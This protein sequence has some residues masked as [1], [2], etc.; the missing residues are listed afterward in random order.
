[1]LLGNLISYAKKVLDRLEKTGCGDESDPCIVAL[2]NL[3]TL[4]PKFESDLSKIKGNTIKGNQQ[5]GTIFKN[6]IEHA[7]R[8][9]I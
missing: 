9:K 3:T 7:S 5:K 2:R 6:G 8:E 1:M 4:K